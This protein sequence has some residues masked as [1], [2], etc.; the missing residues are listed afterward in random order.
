[1]STQ[2]LHTVLLVMFLFCSKLHHVDFPLGNLEL[3]LT[4]IFLYEN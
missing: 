4:T 1:M 3:Q 2:H